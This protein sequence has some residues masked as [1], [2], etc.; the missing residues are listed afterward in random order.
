VSYAIIAVNDYSQPFFTIFGR[1][2]LQEI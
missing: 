2:T 1:D